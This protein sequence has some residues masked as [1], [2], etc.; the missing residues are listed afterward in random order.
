MTAGEVQPTRLT[1]DYRDTTMTTVNARRGGKQAGVVCRQAIS[2]PLVNAARGSLSG[3]PYE[4]PYD[5][6]R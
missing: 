1:D 5:T 6:D 4:D 2:V 3:V